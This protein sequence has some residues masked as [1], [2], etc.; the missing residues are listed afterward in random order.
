MEQRLI[1]FL[2]R[3][4]AILLLS[5][6]STFPAL[7]YTISS[8]SAKQAVVHCCFLGLY[9]WSSLTAA[10]LMAAILRQRRKWLVSWDWELLVALWLLVGVFAI[11]SFYPPFW[12]LVFGTS[13][14]DALGSFSHVSW[15]QN[16]A[17]GVVL[18]LVTAGLTLPIRY[19]RFLMIALPA[20]IHMPTLVLLVFL[21][22]HPLS[23]ET[24]APA[25]FNEISGPL[26]LQLLIPLAG[27]G[28][29]RHEVDRRAAWEIEKQSLIKDSVIID[30]TRELE[31]RNNMSRLLSTFCDAVLLLQPDLN[32]LVAT[33]N[34][35]A[36]LG[37]TCSVERRNLCD[38]I[39][40]EE[41][42]RMCK[43]VL[44]F[45]RGA[46]DET[47]LF[48]CSLRDA[49]GITFMADFHYAYSSERCEL[50]LGISQSS[51]RVP[52]R[53]QDALL[54]L[55]DDQ[56]RRLSVHS[57]GSNRSSGQPRLA[58]G[59][60]STG[61][62]RVATNLSI[63]SS[64][65][66]L[67]GVVG[68]ETSRQSRPLVG[69]FLQLSPPPSA[70]VTIGL[71]TPELT[72]VIPAGGDHSTEPPSQEQGSHL[73]SLIQGRWFKVSGPDTGGHCDSIVV[74]GTEMHFRSG[75]PLQL[76]SHSGSICVDQEGHLT[77]WNG[78]RSLVYS[79]R[80][81]HGFT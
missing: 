4:T 68:E 77:L 51:E 16:V 14:K 69:N 80:D 71:A 39:A 75:L 53:R 43:R 62:R 41:D 70:P 74:S 28:A 45:E 2:I 38:F 1:T 6:W 67:P 49:F 12:C 32:I 18:V 78:E 5:T 73:F 3:G 63:T 29:Y 21:Q 33:R 31:Q 65:S 52:E 61:D 13:L 17:M 22:T 10:L 76:Q 46:R 19:H 25:L 36:L 34:F 35:A 57:S 9:V 42:I 37:S 66:Q 72:S 8:Q 30:Q 48:H 15:S 23:T 47:G 54:E 55:P 50:L 59:A 44:T 79:R 11:V 26:F 20:M 58:P 27:L 64:E 7:H 24:F 56:T 81:P 60:S 40:S